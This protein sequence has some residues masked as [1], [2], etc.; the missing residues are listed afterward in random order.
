[1]AAISVTSA[2]S[3][4]L[5]NSARSVFRDSSG[6]P[7]VLSFYGTTIQISKGNSTTPTSW[8]QYSLSSAGTILASASGAIDSSNVIHIAWMD[9][10]GATSRLV[11]STFTCSTNSFSTIEGLN[12]DIG[13]DPVASNLSCDIAV[14]SNNKPHIVFSTLPKIGGSP[15]YQCKYRNKV[16]GIW[17]STISILGGTKNVNQYSFKIAIG[18]DDKPVIM[19]IYDLQVSFSLYCCLGNANNCTDVSDY[20]VISKDATSRMEYSMLFGPNG[21]FYVVDI[22]TI[23]TDRIY[24]YEHAFEVSWLTWSY[25]YNPN[26]I[27]KT[28]SCYLFKDKLYVFFE[29]TSDDD[30]KYFICDLTNNSF[31]STAT[32]ETGTFN[33]PIAKYS[34]HHNFSSDNAETLLIQSTAFNGSY[35][36]YEQLGM[37]FEGDNCRISKVIFKVS[38]TSTPITGLLRAKLYEIPNLSTAPSG[39]PIAVSINTSDVSTWTTTGTDITWFFQNADI[40]TGKYYAVV[41]D[42]QSLGS[43]QRINLYFGYLVNNL[44]GYTIFGSATDGDDAYIKLYKLPAINEIDYIFI[45]ETATPDIWW[46]LLSLNAPTVWTIKPLKWY[47]GSSWV[48][49]PLKYHNG[50]SWVTKPIQTSM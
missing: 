14:D 36:T 12:S 28:L 31:S 46:N 45:D 15:T 9:D 17:G 4:S 34:T 19:F 25:Y 32:L 13:E 38:R 21:N 6:I 2:N 7:Y 50:S 8:T 27:A 30:I 20:I 35:E 26:N 44:P 40:E 39:N 5:L 33:T 22:S 42:V 23:N 37:T 48:T 29:G 1:M 11:Y 43:N 47:N 10:A 16:A 24:V 49:K 18:I 3:N 41:L